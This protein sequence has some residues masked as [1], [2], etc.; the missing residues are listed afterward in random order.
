M[1]SSDRPAE[2]ND[3][4]RP[5]ERRRR[6]LI[7]YRLPQGQSATRRRAPRP[8]SRVPCRLRRSADLRPGPGPGGGTCRGHRPRAASTASGRRLSRP[9]LPLIRRYHLQQ[10]EQPGVDVPVATGQRGGK[11]AAGGIGDQ[12]GVCCPPR[13]AE[14][15]PGPVPPLTRG[16]GSLR[17]PSGRSP[18]RPHRRARRGE[19]CSAGGQ[20]AIPTPSIRLHAFSCAAVMAGQ[21]SP[22][23]RGRIRE[24]YGAGW[25]AGS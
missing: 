20:G 4:A 2:P 7:P 18:G 25:K 9:H 3:S 13:T 11:G 8:R 16:C 10:R 24:A 12:G 1:P 15:R 19:L 6:A 21:A 23:G 5:T 17:P 22:P 14:P